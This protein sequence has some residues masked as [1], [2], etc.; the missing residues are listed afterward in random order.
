V[1]EVRKDAKET[2]EERGMRERRA[3][4]RNGGACLVLSFFILPRWVKGLGGGVRSCSL[5][6]GHPGPWLI[7]WL[8]YGGSVPCLFTTSLQS[9]SLSGMNFSFAVGD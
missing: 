8:N 5:N 7:S 1:R 2:G 4:C 6:Y 9:L 3:L